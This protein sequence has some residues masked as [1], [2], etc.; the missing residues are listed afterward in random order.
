M[1]K[2]QVLTAMAFALFAQ[3]HVDIAVIEVIYNF[4]LFF[5]F[6]IFLGTV[7]YTRARS[8]ASLSFDKICIPMSF[9]YLIKEECMLMISLLASD[10]TGRVGRC[11]G[12][13]EYHF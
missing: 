7:S 11:P 12:C 5:C 1:G 9:S 2:L 8:H 13:N 10:V 6:S 3:N 4:N